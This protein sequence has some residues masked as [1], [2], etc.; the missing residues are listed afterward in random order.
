MLNSMQIDLKKRRR[1][2]Q[3][4]PVRIDFISYHDRMDGRGATESSADCDEY[5]QMH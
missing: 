3:G 5:S 1:R 4:I 2:K